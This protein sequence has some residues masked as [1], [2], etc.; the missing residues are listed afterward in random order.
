MQASFLIGVL[1][2]LLGGLVNGVCL[3]PMRYTREWEWEN[4][5]IIFTILSTGV[6]P[7][8]AALVAVPNLMSVFRGSS[9]NAFI[10]GLVAGAIGASARSHTDLVSAWWG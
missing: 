8:V 9:F 1:L 6:L 4:T 2:G 7:W 3:L 10:P 5:W